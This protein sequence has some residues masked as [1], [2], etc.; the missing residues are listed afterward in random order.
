MA[1][2]DTARRW[3]D[4][5]RVRRFGLYAFGSADGRVPGVLHDP[6]RALG[7]LEAYVAAVAGPAVLAAHAA[8]LQQ[9][10]SGAG[11]G[12]GSRGEPPLPAPL[13]WSRLV[14]RAPAPPRRVVHTQ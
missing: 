2:R 14:G 13:G 12:D 9:R 6:L 3:A 8:A 4:A 5:M 10:G 7:D 1:P 11:G